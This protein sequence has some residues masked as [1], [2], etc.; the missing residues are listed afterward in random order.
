MSTINSSKSDVVK[1]IYTALMT[2]ILQLAR[3]DCTTEQIDAMLCNELNFNSSRKE[4][5]CRM[6]GKQK[7]RLQVALSMIGTH[8]PHIVDASWKMDYVIKVFRS[9]GRE[10]IFYVTKRQGAVH[11][12][13]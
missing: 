10:I 12:Y 7:E 2:L 13:L 4:L 5:F 9:S 11:F 6:Y 1:E 3:H 8:Y